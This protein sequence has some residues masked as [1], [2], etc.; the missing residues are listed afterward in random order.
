MDENELP[1]AG[2]NIWFQWSDLSPEG[3]SEEE[4]I[5]DANGLFVLRGKQG[6]GL[7]LRITKR[8]YYTPQ[9]GNQFRF[10]NARFWDANYHE[11]NRE[12]PVLFHL[13][14]KGEAEPLIV[15]QARPRVPRGGI[16]VRLD[17]FNKGAI[18]PSGQLEIAAWLPPENPLQ[19]GL[20]DWR[21]KLSLPE[22]GLCEHNDEFPFIA[23]EVGYIPEV[24]FEMPETAPDWRQVI[25][26]RYYFGN[27]TMT[28]QAPG[29]PVH[30]LANQALFK[31]DLNIPRKFAYG[32]EPPTK[33]GRQLSRP[34][35]TRGAGRIVTD[36]HE[37]MSFIARARSK[38]VGAD[39]SVQGAI[40]EKV[41]LSQFGFAEDD[42]DHIAEFA[43]S[44]QRVWRFYRELGTRL[45]LR[46]E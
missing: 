46:L 6:N 20:F 29:F 21:A 26:R 34:A 35:L 22:G 23:P 39:P 8:G 37:S 28:L 13:R 16:P 36:I 41:N 19:R 12:N 1:V 2:A 43:W 45:R 42:Q 38:A 17:L 9:R 15:A 14:R 44:N 18:S 7:S 5:T 11:P 4:T 40:D 10:E 25:T 30:W 33:T 24:V 32:Y 3:A 31:P 27:L